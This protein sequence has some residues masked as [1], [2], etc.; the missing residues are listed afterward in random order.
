[1]MNRGN[2]LM[3]LSTQELLEVVGGRKRRRKG[4][5]NGNAKNNSG[6]NNG[7]SQGKKGCGGKNKNPVQ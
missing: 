5:K 1:M 7:S 6:N 4:K 3:Q 2:E